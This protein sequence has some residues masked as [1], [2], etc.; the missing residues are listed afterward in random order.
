VRVEGT[1]VHTNC[2]A[3]ILTGRREYDEDND[4]SRPVAYPEAFSQVDLLHVRYSRPGILDVSYIRA[5]PRTP[6]QRAA[7]GQSAVQPEVFR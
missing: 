6:F 1:I 5:L 4:W 2:T 7:G 3:S